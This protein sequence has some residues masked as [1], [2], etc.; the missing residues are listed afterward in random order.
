MSTLNRMDNRIVLLTL[1]IA[2][3]AGMSLG[4]TATDLVVPNSIPCYC[5]ETSIWCGAATTQMIL[6]GY[7]GGVDH[8]Y[9]Q[10]HIWNT[11][12]TH[13][14][15]P[16]LN[17][18]TDPDGMRDTLMDLGAG[19]DVHWV[20]FPRPNE[21]E[22]LFSVAYWMK[23]REYPA[24]T[25]VYGFQHWVLITGVTTDADPLTNS[26][27]NLQSIRIFNPSNNPCPTASSGG[28]DSTMTGTQWF[29]GYWYTPG[30]YPASKW[31][32]N[33]IAV[34]EP[35]SEQGRVLADKKRVREGKVISPAEAIDR[36]Y[37]WLGKYRLWETYKVFQNIAHLEPLLIN[38]DLDGYYMVPFGYE[39]G[40]L[41]HGG[42]LVNAYT[43]EFLEIGVFT[44][45]RLLLQREDA[46]RLALNYVKCDCDA[47][48]RDVRLR[49]Q[50]SMQT[51]TAFLPVW[52]VEISHPDFDTLKLFVNMD[53][54]VAK[55]FIPLP[56]GD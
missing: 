11:I 56:L 31:N 16:G 50:A 4:Q 48:I 27:V 43:G 22:L 51:N 2:L 39:Q 40:N 12:Q 35:P 52:E 44:R 18:A 30:N 8:V 54:W 47:Q 49:F 6:E 34:I 1:L 13:L 3:T 15:D 19:T 38:S 41:S 45:P 7:P 26:T 46:E 53:G 25:L 37:E 55:D 24:A 28:V 9:T 23:R 42:I 14:N 29:S 17:W 20:I 10:T 21:D 32:G 36:A 33:Y 5:Q